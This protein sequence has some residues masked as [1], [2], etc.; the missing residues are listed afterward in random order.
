MKHYILGPLHGMNIKVLSIRVCNAG[1]RP[2]KKS[3]PDVIREKSETLSNYLH[4]EPL[5]NE[6]VSFPDFLIFRRPIL[7]YG[8]I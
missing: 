7:D 4:R 5:Y 6:S 2:R 1:G 8:V 3:T